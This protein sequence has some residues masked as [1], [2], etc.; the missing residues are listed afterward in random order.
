MFKATVYVSKFQKKLGDYLKMVISSGEALQVV[1]DGEP[2]RVMITQEY[3]LNLL[4]KVNLYEAQLGLSLPQE[5]VKSPSKEETIA[6][7]QKRL[8]QLDAEKAEFGRYIAE[9]PKKKQRKTK[10]S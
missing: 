8:E 5:K 2:I 10:K 7:L 9:E 3:Y 1:A 6:R 4:S